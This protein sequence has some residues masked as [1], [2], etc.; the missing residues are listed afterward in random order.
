MC[1]WGGGEGG[2]LEHVDAQGEPPIVGGQT[3]EHDGHPW[4]CEEIIRRTIEKLS[5]TAL[6]PIIKGAVKNAFFYLASRKALPPP[7]WSLALSNVTSIGGDPCHDTELAC[8]LAWG[9][10]RGRGGVTYVSAH[11]AGGPSGDDREEDHSEAHHHRARDLLRTEV[12]ARS[13]KRSELTRARRCKGRGDGYDVDEEGPW[14][15]P[16]GW[17]QA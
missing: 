11:H 10:E 14:V 13:R 1:K 3:K 2:D 4:G 16:L 9:G 7:S 6:H 8:C 12:D 5:A 17:H 15:A